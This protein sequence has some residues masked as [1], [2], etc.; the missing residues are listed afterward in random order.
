[1]A[2]CHFFLL[3]V[4]YNIASLLFWNWYLPQINW[5]IVG[6]NSE[7][8]LSPLNSDIGDPVNGSFYFGE[9]EGGLRTIHLQIYPHEDIEVQEIFV[10]RLSLVKGETEIDPKSN[11]ITLI[12]SHYCFSVFRDWYW[13]LLAEVDI[14]IY[15][16]RLLKIN[17][18]DCIVCRLA[19]LSVII[20]CIGMSSVLKKM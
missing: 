9:G 7:E 19:F 12:V 1:M 14:G 10:I 11:N 8:I 6:P 13:Y 15:P 18:M 20:T 3:E 2:L 5:D 16:V 4:Y 17:H